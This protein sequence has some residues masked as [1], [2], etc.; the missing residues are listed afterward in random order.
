MNHY[1]LKNKL[2]LSTCCKNA[3]PAPVASVE[4][5]FFASWRTAQQRV[6]LHVTLSLTQANSQLTQKSAGFPTSLTLDRI[7][8]VSV[9][10]VLCA[11]AGAHC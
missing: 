1:W 5:H 4:A 7:L 3:N 6:G 11:G 8:T 2:C 10:V 9:V